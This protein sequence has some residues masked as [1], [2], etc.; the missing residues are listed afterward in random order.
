MGT[1]VRTVRASHAQA[2]HIVLVGLM[3]SGKST[4]GRLVADALGR[5]LHDSDAA[6]ARDQHR[7]AAQIQSDGGT[8]ALHALEVGNLLGALRSAT[9][10]VIAAAAS[11]IDDPACRRALRADE[12]AVAWLRAD[13][14]ALAGR[15]ARGGHRP[16]F[17]PDPARFLGDQARERNRR[18]RAIRP[19]LVVDTSGRTARETADAVLAVLPRPGPPAFET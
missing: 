19:F 4:V 9:P 5:P 14:V 17:G 16:A 1:P 2:H 8:R 15:F 18:F 6:L 12:V 13:P 11:V 3:G 10:S 7:T